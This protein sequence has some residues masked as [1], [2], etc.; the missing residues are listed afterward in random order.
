[1]KVSNEEINEMEKNEEG[2]FS[3]WSTAINLDSALLFLNGQFPDDLL[4]NRV[5]ASYMQ[6]D[7]KGLIDK[8][9]QHFRKEEIRPTFFIAEHHRKLEQELLKESCK[10]V[11][12]FNIMKLKRFV[13]FPSKYAKVSI[14]D[15]ESIAVWI[16]TYMKSFNIGASFRAEVSRRARMCLKSKNCTLY[17]ARIHGEHVG[18]SL[19]YAEEDVAGFYCIGT[20]SKFRG[21]GV[22]STMLGIMT[23]DAKRN[24][25]QCLQNLQS[26]NVRSFYEKRGFETV[27]TKMVYQQ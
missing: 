14:V 9:L 24:H 22:A 1:M 21:I 26:D 10:H 16:D 19:T 12:S 18:T 20:V 23:R 13:P 11:D 4:F 25:L 27:F 15:A 7:Y 5:S 8:A 2:F 6:Q 3:L 17:I